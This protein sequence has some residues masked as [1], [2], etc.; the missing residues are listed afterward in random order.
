[1]ATL[2]LEKIEQ[3]YLDDIKQA[4]EG[5]GKVSSV[6]A[7]G[8]YAKFLYE[9]KG[10][11]DRAMTF[12]ERMEKACDKE[13]GEFNIDRNN[14]EKENSNRSKKAGAK[15]K[16]SAEDDPR[17]QYLSS[18]CIYLGSFAEFLEDTRQDLDHAEDL[19]QRV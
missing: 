6:I 3:K 13:A 17:L 7:L 18:H 9:I 14:S 4:S 1:M 5:K 2:Q 16:R 19:Y 15:P 8:S 10:E 11:R 12:F